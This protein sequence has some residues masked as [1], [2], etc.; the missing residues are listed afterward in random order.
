MAL[1]LTLLIFRREILNAEK[2]GL[3]SVAVQFIT[4]LQKASSLYML[5]ITMLIVMVSPSKTA[6]TKPLVWLNKQACY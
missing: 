5:L 6:S 3:A 4:G 1:L 2:K